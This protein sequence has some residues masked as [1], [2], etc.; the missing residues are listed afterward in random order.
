MTGIKTNHI[1]ELTTGA[2]VLLHNLKIHVDAT[3]SGTPK[4]IEI[5]IDGT[6]YYAKVYPTKTGGTGLLP[7]NTLYPSTTLYPSDT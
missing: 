4:I 6:S 7:S 2:G 3:L 1:D 5:D